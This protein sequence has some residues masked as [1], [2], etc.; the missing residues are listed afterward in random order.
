LGGAGKARN[1]LS[2]RKLSSF[3]TQTGFALVYLYFDDESGRRESANLL[4]KD[5]ARRMAANFARLPGMLRPTPS[6]L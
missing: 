3:A 1:T 2:I 4:T 6:P 5:E